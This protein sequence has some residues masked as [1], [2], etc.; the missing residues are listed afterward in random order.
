M[1]W[2]LILPIAPV[3]IILGWALIRNKIDNKRFLSLSGVWLFTIVLFHIDPTSVTRFAAGSLEIEQNVEASREIRDQIAEMKSA[4]DSTAIR[5]YK[6]D[7]TVH[8]TALAA[9]AM[10]LLNEFRNSSGLDYRPTIDQALRKC[11]DD[12][13]GLLQSDAVDQEVL[14]TRLLG[15]YMNWNWSEKDSLVVREFFERVIQKR[16]STNQ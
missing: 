12:L 7:S 16:Q 9:L 14:K 4:I 11:R 10:N 3:I 6:V 13:A 8:E 15:K 1:K 5:V 2:S